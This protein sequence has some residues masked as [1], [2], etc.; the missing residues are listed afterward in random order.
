MKPFALLQLGWKVSNSVSNN[1][2]GLFLKRIGGFRNLMQLCCNYELKDYSPNTVAQ[3]EES[4]K[5]IANKCNIIWAFFR[6]GIRESQP[7]VGFHP[8]STM[9]DDKFTSANYWQDPCQPYLSDM[10]TEEDKIRYGDVPAGTRVAVVTK[11][12]LA[13]AE[14][15]AMNVSPQSYNMYMQEMNNNAAAIQA[16][17]SGANSL[18]QKNGGS[19]PFIY[20]HT[21]LVF[22]VGFNLLTPF[23]E[24]NNVVGY[25]TSLSMTLLIVCAYFG[26][27]Q[28]SMRVCNPWGWDPCDFDLEKTGQGIVKQQNRVMK[29]RILKADQPIIH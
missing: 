7:G 28:A 17:F 27:Y 8:G 16:Q 9:V 22:L 11:E 10:L 13:E 26:V 14:K 20:N 24:E 25:Y 6:Q 4:R 23:A 15:L 5:I 29:T 1:S 21:V 19:L 18:L 2:K 3:V 12:L